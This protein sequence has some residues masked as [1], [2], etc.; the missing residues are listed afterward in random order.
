MSEIE[1][2]PEVNQIYHS[3]LEQRFKFVVVICRLDIF[4][5][6]KNTENGQY[7]IL[8]GSL[9]LSLSASVNLNL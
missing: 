3:K 4:P 6:I 7:H 8:L 5:W 9:R 2:G 1:F